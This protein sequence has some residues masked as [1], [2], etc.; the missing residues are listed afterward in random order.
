MIQRRSRELGIAL[1]VLAIPALVF[2]AVPVVSD[3][4]TLIPEG[5]ESGVTLFSVFEGVPPTGE[6]LVREV[7]VGTKCLV[8]RPYGYVETYPDEHHN[9]SVITSALVKDDDGAAI[10]TGR[11]RNLDGERIDLIVLTF[12]LFDSAGNQVT[13]A[14]ATLDYLEPK[15]T[16]SFM[17][18]PVERKDVAFYRFASVFTGSYSGR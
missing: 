2:L 11:I 18:E 14:Y 6:V 16:W 1:I 8:K 7:P 3:E 13:N 12:T 9:L 4:Y 17:T 15:G 5:P 10:V